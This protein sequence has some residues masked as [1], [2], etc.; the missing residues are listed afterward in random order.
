MHI[1]ALAQR[2]VEEKRVYILI[3]PWPKRKVGPAAEKSPT[4]TWTDP[5]RNSLLSCPAGF[6]AVFYLWPL[7]GRLGRAQNVGLRREAFWFLPSW[8]LPSFLTLWQAWLTLSRSRFCLSPPRSLLGS[9]AWVAFGDLTRKQGPKKGLEVSFLFSKVKLCLHPLPLLCFLCPSLN[10]C[11][12]FRPRN[13]GKGKG[14]SWGVVE[15]GKTS[16]PC[17]P[18]SDCDWWPR[19]V[20]ASYSQDTA[21]P[22]AQ[23]RLIEEVKGRERT[24]T[25]WRKFIFVWW[26]FLSDLFPMRVTGENYNEAA[27]QRRWRLKGTRKHS[28][29][30]LPTQRSIDLHTCLVFFLR[31]ENLM[32][33]PA[34]KKKNVATARLEKDILVILRTKMI[35]LSLG[36]KVFFRHCIFL[37]IQ[38]RTR[39]NEQRM[40]W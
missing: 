34:R 7:V 36:K 29:V 22:S 21:T 4:R 30:F 26:C 3:R 40:T 1:L 14:F 31:D 11:L 9:F 17:F 28:E 38:S 18:A 33:V 37:V 35:I 10:T 20:R 2:I 8:F 24:L 13:R 12:Q 23:Y 39:K 19:R 15:W 32:Q 25:A 16:N 27:H 6:S 5:K